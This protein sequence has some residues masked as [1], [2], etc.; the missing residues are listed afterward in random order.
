MDLYVEI[1]N[2][3]LLKANRFCVED[4]ATASGLTT[5]KAR[6]QLMRLEMEGLINQI[7]GRFYRAEKTISPAQF[8]G[9]ARVLTK[10]NGGCFVSEQFAEAVGIDGQSAATQLRRMIAEG[11]VERVSN[12]KYAYIPKTA[13]EG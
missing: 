7:G 8:W 3:L 10:I 13:A 2:N 11:Q 12:T 4:F 6:L 5:T 9:V 1:V